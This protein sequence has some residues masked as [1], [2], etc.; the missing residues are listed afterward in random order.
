LIGAVLIPTLMALL[1]ALLVRTVITSS[2][3][4]RWPQVRTLG[5]TQAFR[6]AAFLQSDSDQAIIWQPFSAESDTATPLVAQPI[7]RKGP[8]TGLLPYPDV[9]PERWQ[10]APASSESFHVVWRERDERLRSAL[11]AP[12]GKTQRGPITLSF[13]AGHDFTTAALPDHSLLAVWRSPDSRQVTAQIIDPVGRPDPSTLIQLNHAEHIAV[14]ADHAGILHFA[15]IEA[16]ASG[17]RTFYYQTTTPDSLALNAPTP[18]HTADLALSESIAALMLGLDHTHAY[19]VWSIAHADR[20]DIERVYVLAFPL[21]QPHHAPISELRLPQNPAP[22]R[23]LAADTSPLTLDRVRPLAAAAEPGAALRWPGVTPGQNTVLPLAITYRTPSGWRPGVVYFQ[24]GTPLGYQQIADHP[25]DAGPPA[26]AIGH[27]GRVVAAWS[28]LAGT[29]PILYSATLTDE[30]LAAP[31]TRPT[32]IALV[33]G[34]VAG[35]AWSLWWR[36]YRTDSS[37]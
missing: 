3:A 2:G 10:V 34:L 4:Y 21:G 32:G 26:V 6:L 35:A 36:W 15:W 18:I 16:V 37:A 28:G 20:P 12:D 25:A 11:I 13:R 7:A 8:T 27:A 14:A 17:A 5:Q 29:T 19:L 22:Y 30:G 31:S 24:D 1:V 9:M 33:A 23:P